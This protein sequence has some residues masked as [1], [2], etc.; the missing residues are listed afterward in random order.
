MARRLRTS[1]EQVPALSPYSDTLALGIMVVA[2]TYVSLI[3]GELVPKR[4]AL[5]HPERFASIIARPMQ[6]LA[7]IARPIILLL[8]AL[9]DSILR[10]V[11]VRQ[12]KQPG[13]TV[14]A[15]RVMLEQGWGG[16]RGKPH[17]CDL[18]DR[19]RSSD[20]TW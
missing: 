14:D 3:L 10:L 6:V 11:G 5:T 18:V 13:V 9:T 19:G 1:F 17:R 12:A 16:G 20:R 8:S 4:L 15:I 2:L 7:K